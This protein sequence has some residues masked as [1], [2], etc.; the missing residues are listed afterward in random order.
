MTYRVISAEFRTAAKTY[1]KLARS[2]IPEIAIIGRSNVGKSSFINRLA[3]K[4]KL[5]RT[6][7]TPGR[8]RELNLF[9]FEIELAR[10]KK[11]KL[12]VIDLPGFGFAKVSKEEREELSRLCF[13]YV[14]R[15][16]Q[17][18]VIC[19]LNDCRRDAERDELAIRDLAF[20]HDKRLLVILTKTDKLKTSELNKRTQSVADSYGLDKEDLILTGEKVPTNVFW[21]RVFLAID[22]E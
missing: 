22:P 2:P 12:N 19:L 20:E 4:K 1:T 14:T 15:R 3:N 6:S 9:D 17:L 7:N 16:D 8:T 10:N 5:A 13:E 11:K 18:E 21:E